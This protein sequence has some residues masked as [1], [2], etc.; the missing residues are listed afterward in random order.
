[1]L[2]AVIFFLLPFGLTLALASGIRLA[3]GPERGARLA[4]IAVAAGF[5]IAW[6]IIL[7]PGWLAEEPISRTGH[8]A[9][10]AALLGLALDFFAAKRLW[11]AAVAGF[12][13]LVETWAS[14]NSGFWPPLTFTWLTA[15][16]L[17][18]LSVIAFFVLARLDAMATRGLSALIVLTMLAVGVGVIALIAGDEGVARSVF[19]LA[20][21]V[22]GYIAA[23]AFVTLPAGDAV[24]LGA[25]CAL[26]AFAWALTQ[27]NADTGVLLG[28]VLL[29]LMLFAEGTARRVPLPKAR[30]SVFLYPL[31]LAGV[32][33]LP[34]ALAALVTFAVAGS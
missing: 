5:L 22:A 25:G 30:I 4:G 27:R 2:N 33:A 14:L 20:L 28:L 12:V 19:L 1:M 6:G 31:I 23:N 10:G 34:L 9:A 16:T 32:A 18:T 29:P 3:G 7:R 17:I 11:A 21:A 8:I 13:V 15:V 24:I 26:L